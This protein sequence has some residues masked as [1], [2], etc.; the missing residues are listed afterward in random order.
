[1]NQMRFLHQGL[2]F[3]IS[4]SI[5]LCLTFSFLFI[6]VWRLKNIRSAKINRSNHR[7]MSDVKCDGII[8]LMISKSERI[9]SSTHRKICAVSW[10]GIFFLMRS[11]SAIKSSSNHRKVIHISGGWT[12]SEKISMRITI[13]FPLTRDIN[14]GKQLLRKKY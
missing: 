13:K 9:S 3:N 12:I 5:S 4:S 8:S 2:R 6:L 7:I 1:M 10:D 11:R 14:F